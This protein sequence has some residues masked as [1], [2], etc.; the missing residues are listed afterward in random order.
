MRPPGADARFFGNE[1]RV[2][3]MNC[4]LALPPRKLVRARRGARATSSLCSPAAHHTSGHMAEPCAA[5]EASSVL[6]VVLTAHQTRHRALLAHHSWC[7]GANCLFVA[8]DALG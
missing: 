2:F 1:L 6:F 5:G 7:A 8:E 3:P 4:P